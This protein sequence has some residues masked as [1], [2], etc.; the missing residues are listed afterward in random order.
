MIY[1]NNC[2]ALENKIKKKKE[3]KAILKMAFYPI[4]RLLPT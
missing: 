4:D 1:K 2:I 3:I